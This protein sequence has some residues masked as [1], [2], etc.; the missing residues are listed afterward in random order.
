MAF[1]LLV[2]LNSYTVLFCSCFILLVN[3]FYADHLVSINFLNH[4]YLNS[5]TVLLCLCFYFLYCHLVNLILFVIICTYSF[6]FICTYGTDEEVRDLEIYLS[7]IVNNLKRCY[8]DVAFPPYFQMDFWYE[9]IFHAMKIRKMKSLES[10]NTKLH[11]IF[12]FFNV[13]LYF[14]V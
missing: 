4:N 8:T 12:I 9:H 5:T 7:I 11:L 1:T 13:W 10:F 14:T 2:F 6:N 3:L